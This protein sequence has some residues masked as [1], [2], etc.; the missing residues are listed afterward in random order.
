[1]ARRLIQETDSKDQISVQG[2]EICAFALDISG[3]GI[4]RMD[5]LSDDVFNHDGELP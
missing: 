1:M 4:F 5:G 3:A 2:L